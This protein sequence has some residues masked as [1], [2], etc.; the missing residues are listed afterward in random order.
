MSIFLAI[1]NKYAHIRDGK[2]GIK[3]NILEKPKLSDILYFNKI[4]WIIVLGI[5]FS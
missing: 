3:R 2:F 1:L 5:G 4:Y